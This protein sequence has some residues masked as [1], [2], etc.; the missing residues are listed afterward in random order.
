[1]SKQSKTAGKTAERKPLRAYI[2]EA[3]K[4]YSR[5][6]PKERCFIRI[7]G[8]AIAGAAFAEL[9]AIKCNVLCNTFESFGLLKGGVA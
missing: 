7:A 3:I 4:K 6:N 8:N 5:A 9:I 2:L 1:M